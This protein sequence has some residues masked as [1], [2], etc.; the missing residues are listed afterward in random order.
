M[1]DRNP[2]DLVFDGLAAGDVVAA[3][4][5]LTPDA[6]VWHSF[7]RI[8]YDREAT[9]REWAAF[10][11]A[12]PERAFTHVRRQPTPGGFVQQHVMTV[13]TAAGQYL[14]WEVCVVVAVEGNRIRQLDEY[15]DRAGSFSPPG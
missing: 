13:R 12:F 7:D 4:E 1:S 3:L 9:A 2:L 6:H 8:A 11:Q 15:L 14:S 5:G 10:V